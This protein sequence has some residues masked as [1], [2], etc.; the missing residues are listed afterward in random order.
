[1]FIA[2]AN[3]HP[4]I[5]K[6]NRGTQF[7]AFGSVADGETFMRS[8]QVPCSLGT[9]DE[10][11][12]LNPVAFP[13]QFGVLYLP[14]RQAIEMFAADPKGFPTEE[15]LV[16]LRHDVVRPPSDREELSPPTK[17]DGQGELGF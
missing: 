4:L 15:Y 16:T 17:S 11:L 6:T 5:I 14:T 8:K 7:I 10:I 2:H 1:M 9:L 3:G 12:R 13:R